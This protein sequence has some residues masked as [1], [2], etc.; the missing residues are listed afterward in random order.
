MLQS[1]ER[2]I[3]VRREAPA[4]ETIRVERVRIVEDRRVAMAIAYAHPDEPP[5]RNFV[6][7][8]L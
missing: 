5:G 4:G 2:R 7:V 8:D 6:T 3:L 1:A